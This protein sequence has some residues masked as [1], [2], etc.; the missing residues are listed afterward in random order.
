M[1]CLSVA[2]APVAGQMGANPPEHLPRSTRWS[3]LYL[4]QAVSPGA[5]LSPKYKPP[6]FLGDGAETWPACYSGDQTLLEKRVCSQQAAIKRNK[7]PQNQSNEA[8]PTRAGNGERGSRI[9]RL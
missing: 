8:A 6:D 9:Y 3:V 1:L 7:C 5:A 2:V 4:P